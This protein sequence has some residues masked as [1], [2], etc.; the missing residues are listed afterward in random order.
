[1]NPSCIN[2]G[3]DDVDILEVYQDGH[4]DVEIFECYECGEIFEEDYE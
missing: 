3:S 2:C 4:V 1:M